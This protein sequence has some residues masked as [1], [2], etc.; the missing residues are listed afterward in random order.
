MEH[1]RD[2]IEQ[3][4][5]LPTNAS[6]SISRVTGD[7]WTDK[8]YKDLPWRR[9]SKWIRSKVGERFDRVYSEWGQLEWVPERHRSMKSIE[10]FLKMPTLV[11][12]RLLDKRGDPIDDWHKVTYVDP[13]TN[14]IVHRQLPKRTY[15][16]ARRLKEQ[17]K[18]HR[19][20]GDYHQLIK[21]KGIWYDV[22]I[23]LRTYST[24][25]GE[26]PMPPDYA[27]QLDIATPGTYTKRQ[28]NSAE[29]KKH[30]LQN[31]NE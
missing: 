27:F 15:G 14:I 10:R 18:T 16:K 4:E 8:H 23:H 1:I 22:V 28:L 7:D 29:L 17:L 24:Y 2:K 21:H 12:G 31:D 25:W 9:A 26:R 5:E 6:T 19:I 3:L 11:G 30:E 20:I 13:T